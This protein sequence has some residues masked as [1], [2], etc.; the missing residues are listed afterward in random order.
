MAGRLVMEEDWVLV[1]IGGPHAM[2]CADGFSSSMNI[3][4]GAGRLRADWRGQSLES[5]ESGLFVLT[6]STSVKCW[7]QVSCM[8]NSNTSVFVVCAPDLKKKGGSNT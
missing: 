5:L 6:T 4:D 3:D 1:N 8:I 2:P 7:S